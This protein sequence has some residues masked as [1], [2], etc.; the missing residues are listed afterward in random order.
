MDLGIKN[1]VALVAASSKG[2]GKAVA[3]QLSKEGSKVVICARNKDRLFKTR[4]E[5]AAETGGMVRALIADVT[6]R[7]QVSKL[8]EQVVNE[9]GTIEILVNNAGG[10]PSGTADE[11]NL[12]DYQNALKLN[13]LS[14]INLCYE[15]M[16][17]MKKQKWGRIINMTSVSAKQPIDTLILSNTTRTGVLGFSKSISNQLASY[18][19]TVNSVC[20]GYTKTERVEGL[21]KFFEESGKGSVDEFY[22][23]IEKAIP[24]GRLGTPEEI[25][26]AVAFLASE[27]ASYITGVA[28]QIDGGYIKALF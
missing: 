25:A 21:A 14:T 16:P 1:R 15:V 28:L 11:F 12:D 4:D 22:N 3:L 13:L 26:Q 24:M 23:N 5:I 2:L 8:V 19:I 7:S 10:P 17:L 27:G 9:F 6:E 20:P 18:G